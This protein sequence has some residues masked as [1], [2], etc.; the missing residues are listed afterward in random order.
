MF[1]LDTAKAS[2][3]REWV[4]GFSVWETRSAG[5]SSS[6][7]V[8]MKAETVPLPKALAWGP[9]RLKDIGLPLDSHV[10]EGIGL[11]VPV[12]EQEEPGYYEGFCE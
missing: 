11:A 5:N 7:G 3:Q 8:C 12:P 10:L 1:L 4:G 2:L 9:G 6:G